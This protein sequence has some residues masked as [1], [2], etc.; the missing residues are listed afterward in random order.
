MESNDRFDKLTNRDISIHYR[1]RDYYFMKSD[2]MGA[3]SYWV[4]VQSPYSLPD[5]SSPLSAFY[6]YLAFI[7]AD[8]LP[9]KFTYDELSKLI[10]E[11]VFESIPAINEL[12]KPKIDIGSGITAESRYHKPKPDYDFIDLGALARNIFYMM[13]RENITQSS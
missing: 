11:D 13:L 5:I 9:K 2:F 12:N 7:F 4:V 10:S 6:G 8:E 3:F 1:D